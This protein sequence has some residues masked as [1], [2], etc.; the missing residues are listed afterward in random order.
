MISVLHQTIMAAQTPKRL[1]T[2]LYIQAIPIELDEKVSFYQNNKYCRTT[3]LKQTTS[4]SFILPKIN[5]FTFL[6]SAV[7]RKVTRK[8]EKVE[9]N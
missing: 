8:E 7:D 9:V 3:Y 6:N 4:I 1:I 2:H 5:I